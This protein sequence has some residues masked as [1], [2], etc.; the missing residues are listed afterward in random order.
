MILNHLEKKGQFQKRQHLKDYVQNVSDSM[1]VQVKIDLILEEIKRNLTDI[2]GQ[3]IRYN[4]ATKELDL[5]SL[6]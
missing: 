5:E 4:W 3:E 1:L 6:T 2:K